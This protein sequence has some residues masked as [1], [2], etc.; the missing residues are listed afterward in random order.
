[1]TAPLRAR[2]A[3]V[4][5][6]TAG[7][8]AALLMARRG[9]DVVCLDR[10][11]LGEAGARWVNG[12]PARA[13]DEAG[14]GKP[15]G[16]ELCGE[17]HAFHLVAGWGPRRVTVRDHG[18][19]EVD[20]RALVARLQR[21]A[22]EAGAR[23]VG[24][25][26]V[27]GFDGRRL[28]T[29]AGPVEADV[30]V[31]AS[32][33]GGAGLVPIPDV[34]PEDI[35]AAAQEVREL[36]DPGAARAFCEERGVPAGESLCFSGVAG[37]YSIVNVRLTGDAVSILT[38]SVPA[39]GFPSG[40]ALLDTFAAEHSWV[41][42]ARYGG[43]RPIPLR[44]PADRLALGNVALLGDAGRQVFTAHG[45][46]IAAGLLA[47]SDLAAALAKDPSPAGILRYQT[48]YMR[49]RG[50]LLAS[51][52]AFRRHSRTLTAADIGALM[53]SGLISE[54]LSRPTL[55]QEALP[56]GPSVVLQALAGAVRAPRAVARLAPVLLRMARLRAHYA[57][58]PED[59]DR[60]DAWSAAA[61]AIAQD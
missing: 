38:G 13:F 29:T 9:L 60:V 14:I 23:L 8:A 52:D 11:P 7:A 43:A 58:Y 37:G 22:E 10:R 16:A 42:P 51:Y 30:F 18:V 47:A 25:A 19:L 55:A 44:R 45:S 49:R 40:K 57:R 2:V 6:G 12:V 28:E 33:M 36:G 56:L 41:G 46:G 34:P 32:G 17:G 1:M 20:M 54:E 15:E 48:A 27:V 61:R 39:L 35:C 26:R 21:G 31:D 53:E 59:P 4:G 50:G 24:E 5:A 3:V